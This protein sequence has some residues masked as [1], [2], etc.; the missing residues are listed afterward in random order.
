[1]AGR[2]ERFRPKKKTRAISGAADD[3]GTPNL[4]TSRHLALAVDQDAIRARVLAAATAVNPLK[5]ETTGVRAL[6]RLRRHCCPDGVA[7]ERRDVWRLEGL[8]APRGA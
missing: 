3:P 2:S 6:V 5:R 1:V 7:T 8:R 4:G